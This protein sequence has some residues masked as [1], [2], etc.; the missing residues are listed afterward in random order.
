MI[1]T[2]K[3]LKHL[4][5]KWKTATT[6]PSNL[7]EAVSYIIQN[8]TPLDL[9]KFSKVEAEYAGVSSNFLRGM[10]MRNAWKLW[11]KEGGLNTWF[12]TN[13]I[14]HGDDKSSIVYKAVWCKLNNAPFDIV[15]ERRFYSLFWAA[16]GLDFDGE[17]LTL[18]PDEREKIQKNLE[19]AQIR[20]SPN[21]SKRRLTVVQP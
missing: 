7:D 8:N 5:S 3:H 4:I 17:P 19:E 6:I 16:S 1:K 18:T 13:G 20:R 2:L 15:E 9:T 14:W 21:K 10:A 12:R 11:E